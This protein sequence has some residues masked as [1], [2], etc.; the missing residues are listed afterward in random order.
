MAYVSDGKCWTHDGPGW[1]GFSRYFE[2]KLDD[3]IARYQNESRRIYGVLDKQ[4]A[5]EE[6]LAGEYSIAEQ[7][8]YPWL[9]FADCVE[10]LVTILKI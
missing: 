5:S 8:H 1:R 6:Y 3:A 2:P 9:C 4:L 10:C 7:G